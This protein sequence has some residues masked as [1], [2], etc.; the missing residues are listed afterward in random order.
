M[1]VSDL[2]TT[3]A[4]SGA[5]PQK[6]VQALSGVL[7]STADLKLS[8]HFHSSNMAPR[9]KMAPKSS[10]RVSTPARQVLLSIV[11]LLCP[12]TTL[13]RKGCKL[14]SLCKSVGVSVCQ[15]LQPRAHLAQTLQALLR[16]R[17]GGPKAVVVAGQRVHRGVGLPAAQSP[18]SG[19]LKGPNA[20]HVLCKQ[21]SAAI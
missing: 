9:S 13:K 19:A 16:Q 10:R 14:Q 20:G 18:A 2:P 15:A 5:C 4:L 6:L 7:S 11:Q 3:V 12:A 8:A 17:R 21:T 1:L